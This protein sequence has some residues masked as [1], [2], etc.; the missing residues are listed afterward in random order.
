MKRYYKLISSPC[1]G[2]IVLTESTWLLPSYGSDAEKDRSFADGKKSWII[3]I[4]GSYTVLADTDGGCDRTCD[5]VTYIEPE[6]ENAVFRGKELV[7]FYYDF[8]YFYRIT[9]RV[10][11]NVFMFENPETYVYSTNKTYELIRRREGECYK[12]SEHIW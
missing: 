8:G 3:K 11:S 7:G 9:D 12:D 2:A 1:K 4:S 10:N 5:Y 6:F